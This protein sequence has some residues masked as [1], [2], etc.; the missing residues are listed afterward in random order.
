[1]RSFKMKIVVLLALGAGSLFLGAV[2]HAANPFTSIQFP[3]AE[4]GNCGDFNA[5]KIYCDDPANADACTAWGEA[6]GLI[7]INAQQPPA[8]SPINEVLANGG[9]PG[10]CSSEDACRTY[11][12]DITHIQECVAFGKA[13]GLLSGKALQQAEKIAALVSQG[14]QMPGGCTSKASCG[15]YC[16]ESAHSSECLAFAKKTGLLSGD[17]AVQAQKFTDLISAGQGPGGCTSPSACQTY[18]SDPSH[19]SECASFAQK[20]GILPPGQGQQMAPMPPGGPGGC[21]SA[22]SCAAY[23]NDPANQQTCVDFAK[24]YG[25]INQ[26]QAQSIMHGL[27]NIDMGLNNAPAQVKDC[28]AQAVGQDTLSQLEQGTA[29]SI[30]TAPKIQ[31]CFQS[32]KPQ[33]QQRMQQQLGPGT[34]ACIKNLVGGTALQALENGGTPPD[35]ATA[36]KIGQC[37]GNNVPPPPQQNGSFPPGAFAS[38]TP[39]QNGPLPPW[40]GEG[41]PPNNFGSGTP[42]QNWQQQ[43]SST[44]GG[45]QPPPNGQPYQQPPPG[46]PPPQ[47]PGNFQQGNQEPMQPPYPQYQQQ[48]SGT[49]PQYQSQ[50]MYPSSSSTL[51]FPP[52]PITSSSS[53]SFNPVTFGAAVFNAFGQLFNR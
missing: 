43:G 45:M 53:S 13:H 23:C 47:Y 30:D 36:Q 12:D 25:L 10:G 46:M 28:I 18:C 41:F 49:Q 7:Q 26:T 34:Q 39:P 8:P 32:F 37:F 21:D 29:P 16:S 4:L 44:G 20:A 31:A 42:P 14:V 6:H 35:P 15:A 24:Q 19:Q 48:A 40:N 33:M 1:M 3:I 2:A 51:P 9:G 11:C 38:G 22:D 52:P 17:A 5:C 50:P 27:G